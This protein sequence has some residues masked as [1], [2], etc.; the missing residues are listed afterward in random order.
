MPVQLVLSVNNRDT[1]LIRATGS[2]GKK[3]NGR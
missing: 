1:V 2:E 3:F